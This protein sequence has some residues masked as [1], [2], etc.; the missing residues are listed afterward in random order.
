[1]ANKNRAAVVLGRKGG[2]ARAKNLSA[3]EL[4][5]QGKKAAEERWKQHQDG[6]DTPAKN[7]AAKKKAASAKKPAKKK[8]SKRG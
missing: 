8:G 1:M 7:A 3:E 6:N 2:K 4:S 5:T